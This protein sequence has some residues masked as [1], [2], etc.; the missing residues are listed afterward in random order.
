MTAPVRRP[1]LTPRAVR[2]R[3]A[4][5]RQLSRRLRVETPSASELE[6]L[7]EALSLR[8]AFARFT[9]GRS[10]MH[11][12]PELPRAV[13]PRRRVRVLGVS[14]VA[15]LLL[16][17]IPTRA[18]VVAGDVGALPAGAVRERWT[19]VSDSLVAA[20]HEKLLRVGASE[21][22]F[23]LSLSG[24]ELAALVLRSP[25]SR[26]I[27]VLAAVEARADSVLEVRGWLP[28]G[29]RVV[30]RADV[31]VRRRGA[32]EARVRSLTV[33][34]TTIPAALLSQGMGRAGADDAPRLTFELP[35]FVQ[36]I[37]L[38]RGRALV[39]PEVASR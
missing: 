15:L 4:W 21:I 1:A 19:P 7:G 39:V 16:I 34:G 23:P 17:V 29:R 12:G 36:A 25:A 30:L 2:A 22:R 35:Y 5:I 26:R 10:A 27:A 18:S 38:R 32:G 6:G 33:D 11:L 37:R 28:G 3:N 31:R 24:A 9:N 8:E 13:G 20:V 14:A